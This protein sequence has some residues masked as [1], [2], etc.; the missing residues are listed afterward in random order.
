MKLTNFDNPVMSS[1]FTIK[2]TRL[3]SKPYLSG[4]LEARILLEKLHVE[5]QPLHEVTTGI[6]HAGREGRKYVDN[7]EHGVPF[8]RSTDILAADLSSL[9]FLSKKQI[10]ANPLL[11]LQEGW[12][13]ITRSGTVGRMAFVRPDMAGM[14][15]SEDVMRVV[16][17]P[18]KILP[19]YLYAY[20]S[21]KF[22]VPQVTEGTYGAII[23]HL[24]PSHIINLDVPRLNRSIEEVVHRNITRAANL[25]SE[26]QVEVK[27]ATERL[28]SSLGLRDITTQE[29]QTMGPNLGFSH[30]IT[31][32]DTLRAVNFNPRLQKLINELAKTSHMSLGAICKNGMLRRGP[33][34]KRIDC[35]PEFGVKLVGQREL[36]WL[37]PEG[38]WVSAHNAP[39]DI[40]VED[41]TILVTSQ[42]SIG[43]TELVTG[44]WTQYAYSEHFLRVRSSEPSLSNLFLFAFLRSETAY[45]CLTS[46]CVG[47]IQQ[48][49]HH[50]LLFKLPV[51]IPPQKVRDTIE[52]LV[53]EAYQKRHEASRL[54]KAA[55]EMVE[56]VIE[57]GAKWQPLSR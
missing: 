8:L 54:E 26:Y 46:F 28:F 31:S 33:R 7:P 29:W 40:F 19:G 22:G 37:K 57:E 47:T 13:L 34:F 2:G 16:P 32:S 4:A 41:E 14:A 23:Q 42:G 5:K 51:P 48:D 30:A 44:S 9:P 10:E 20:L 1:W 56:K 3:D 35:E 27:S 24:E 49:L 39:G 17:D 43:K 25:R 21:S 11:L 55:V 53:R 15:C 45:R 12:T 6:Y 36:F 50:S 38:R 52:I 18:D